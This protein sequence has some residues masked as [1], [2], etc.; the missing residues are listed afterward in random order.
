[1][2]VL[3][4]VIAGGVLVLAGCAGSAAVQA[5]TP[6]VSETLVHVSRI[7]A[8]AGVRE[9]AAD[10]SLIVRVRTEANPQTVAADRD[11][12]DS[13]MESTLSKV[14]VL[15]AIK[16][17]AVGQLAIRQTGSD[18][19]VVGGNAEILRPGSEYLLF[20]QPFRWEPDG[21][22]TGEWIITGELGAYRLVGSAFER[23]STD[24]S[25]LPTS[26]QAHQLAT[27]TAN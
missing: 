21:A 20:L 3:L 27:L 4:P 26:L 5:P 7:K 19:V 14:T 16:G 10:S 1:M 6:G 22:D 23:T 8:F 18:R 25:G 15:K 13:A 24:G 12:A 11:A 17:D 9:L 2:R